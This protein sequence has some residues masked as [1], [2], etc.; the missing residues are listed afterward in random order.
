M[1]Y[2]TMSIKPCINRESERR[3]SH[4]SYTVILVTRII[5]FLAV[6]SPLDTYQ[7]L[8][9]LFFLCCCDFFA[10][11]L[12]FFGDPEPIVHPL[13]NGIVIVSTHLTAAKN[14][15]TSSTQGTIPHNT[16]ILEK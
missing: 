13:Y 15:A 6:V 9:V 14:C 7:I 10:E 4:V 11:F 1:L 2:K 16:F 8:T 5:N 3:I 12:I